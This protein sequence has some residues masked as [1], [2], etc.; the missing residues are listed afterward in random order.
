M[1]IKSF[2]ELNNHDAPIAGGKGASLG[3]L[4]QA[5][6]SVPPWFVVLAGTFEKFLA[7]TDLSVE[8]EAILKT[9]EIDKMHTVEHAAE[10]IQALILAAKM[11]ENIAK[12]IMKGYRTLYK[13]HPSPLLIKERGQEELVAVRSSATAEDSLEAAWAGQLESYLNTTEKD[14]L[15]NVKKCWASLFSSR[16][17]F[18]R[19]E[20]NL[21]LSWIKIFRSRG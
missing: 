21:K 5:G 8:I 10:K 9:V 16:A 7:E 19:C 15:T 12:E 13:P 6:I 18:Y 4:T 11:P 14:L 3:E 1:F 17:I 2:N 20:K